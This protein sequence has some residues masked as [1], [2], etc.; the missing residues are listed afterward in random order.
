MKTPLGKIMTSRKVR[1]KQLFIYNL[2]ISFSITHLDIYGT[3]ALT[4]IIAHLY[5]ITHINVEFLK[6]S[7]V[8]KRAIHSIF[9]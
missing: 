2:E 9:N 4:L 7:F 3:R 8:R 1:F 5:F 6:K